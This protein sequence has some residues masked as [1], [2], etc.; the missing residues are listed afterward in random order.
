MFGVMIMPKSEKQKLK[1]LYIAEYFLK[2]TDENHPTTIKDIIDY[3]ET[4][5]DI[6]AERRSVLR[7]IL[8]LRD[9]FGMDIECPTQGGSY[10]RLLSRD[11]ELDDL[12]LLAE[13]VYATK[14]ISQ[15]KAKELVEKI[16]SLG[17][18]FAAE[19]L[20]EE[21]FL[22]DRVKTN[23]K[24]ILNNIANINYAMSRRWDAQPRTPSKIS[25]QYM[26]YQISDVHSQVERRKG[27]AYVVSPFKLL[28]NDGNYYLLAYSDYA[29]AM[30]TFRIDRIK[31]VKVLEDQPRE[32]EDEYL[33]IDMDSYTQRVFSMFGGKKRR[34]RI[35]FINPL[36]DTAI[37]RFGTKDAIYT[38][39]DNS[40][41]IVAATVEISDQ[42]LAW[43][44]G[45]RKKATIIA[46]SD[47]VEDMKKFLSDISDR[48]KNE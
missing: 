17:S 47:V 23:R 33:S 29:K 13:C 46:P 34:V 4:E 43:V 19:Q 26:K 21:V 6:L 38:A 20:Q 44:C 24:G 9:E 39:D 16:G 5:H 37:E 3:L 41:F 28:I 2:N 42:F 7:D 12:K 27:A 48:Y 10:Y 1:T 8:V 25:F 40:H 11:F 36:L 15:N 22:C 18:N 45:F 32:G 30:R 31:N 35:R 14:F